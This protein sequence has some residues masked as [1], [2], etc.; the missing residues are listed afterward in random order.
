MNDLC[1]ILC[2]HNHQPVGNFGFVLEDAYRRAY[3]PFVKVMAAHPAIRF[4]IH[5]SG[6]LLE[7]ME[8]EH[9]EYVELL[10]EMAARGQ[11]EILT[12]GFYEPILA[13]IPDA[14]KLLQI[15]RFSEY[16]AERFGMKPRGMWLAER[17]WEPQLARWLSDAGIEY[18][19]LDDF[20]FRACG[21]KQE[22]LVSHFTVEDQGRTIQ[23]FPLSEALRYY[24]P[25]R[26][27]TETE[28]YLRSLAEKNPGSLAVFGDDGEKFGIWP[29]THHL[30]YGKGWL[31]SFL[32]MLEKNSDWLQTVTF[33]EWLETHESAG[34]AY[35]PTL[36]YP[37]MME[38]ALPAD[39]RGE[40]QRNR[41]VLKKE[42][43]YPWSP[44]FLRGA[45]W[46]S[47]LSKYP[48]SYLMYRK[49]LDVRCRLAKTDPEV[50][51]PDLAP[52]WRDLWRGQC[53]CAYWHGVFGGLYL[54]HLRTE[55]Y[56][57]LISAEVR[58]D[59]VLHG[60]KS[61]SE[62]RTVDFDGD[63]WPEILLSDPHLNVYLAPRRGGSMFELDFKPSVSNLLATLARRP[64]GYHEDLLKAVGDGSGD[65]EGEPR[66]IHD[67]PVAKEKGLETYLVFDR[68]PADSWRDRF[69][70]LTVTA[71]E[72]KEGR[73]R[74]LGDFIDAPYEVRVP[75]GESSGKVVLRRVGVVE[76]PSGTRKIKITKSISRGRPGEVILE[77]DLQAGEEPVAGVLFGTVFNLAMSTGDSPECYYLIDGERSGQALLGC[78]GD[79]DAVGS[80]SLIDGFLST[81]VDFR[82]DRPARV[83]RFPVITVSLSESGYEKAYQSSVVMPFWDVR[84]DAGEH[85][86]IRIRA[87]ISVLEQAVEAK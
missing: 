15:S 54:K 39:R 61:W 59:R 51:L 50:S 86:K 38:W 30:V 29:G 41:E 68:Y 42:F 43:H 47:F 5:N 84:L 81:C 60:A 40:Y 3:L 33:S 31:A 63:G 7:W 71:G 25:F 80:V 20:H 26:S 16:L 36:A 17:V 65:P 34:L 35:L 56:R 55:V 8:E 4:V 11:V 48:E 12:G 52:A 1:L 64:E 27:V 53:N 83:L 28:E 24:V 73:C 67:G 45:Y 85:L 66:S 58:L 75:E 10:R 79:D 22:A 70:P 44:P 46:R 14:D 77:H 72:M 23:V 18:T 62:C 32:Q 82:F 78:E 13:M 76:T 57:R 49:M 87:M 37:E 74:E 69:A 2:I 21:L 19:G 6:C 9:P